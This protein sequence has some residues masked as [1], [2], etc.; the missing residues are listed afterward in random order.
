MGESTK[1]FRLIV[2]VVF[3][4]VFVEFAILYL[5]EEVS[6]F[7]MLEI[8]SVALVALL[9]YFIV[10]SELKM[11]LRSVEEELMRIEKKFENV[12]K[13]F[14]KVEISF[15]EDVNILKKEVSEL[16]KLLRKLAK[17]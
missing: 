8:T 7:K 3:F 17:K 1:K 5:K 12:E 11:A 10:R 15:D 9:Y 4:I 14:E 13:R 16:K 6:L 2:S